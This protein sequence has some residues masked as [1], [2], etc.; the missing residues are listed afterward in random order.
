MDSNSIISH[1]ICFALRFQEQLKIILLVTFLCNHKITQI[2]T[3]TFFH[4]ESLIKET[5][6]FLVKVFAC[7]KVL[8]QVLFLKESVL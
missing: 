4:K 5:Y 1:C 2:F 3:Q 6:L 7:K 8:A